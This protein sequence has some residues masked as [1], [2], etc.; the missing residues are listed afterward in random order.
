MSGDARGSHWRLQHRHVLLL[1]CTRMKL[2]RKVRQDYDRQPYPFGTAKALTHKSWSL[3]LDW[4]D[5][6]CGTTFGKGAEVRVLFAGCGD[7]SEAFAFQRRMPRA[8]IV[9]VDFS[10]RSI[11]V[12]RRLQRLEAAMRQIH[13][14]AADLTDPR[15]PATVGGDFD[16]IICHGVLSYITRP[17]RALINL[18]RCLKA[19]GAL[20]LGVNG[21]THVS[22]RL[23]LAL[24]LLGHDLER[25]KEGE[26][27]REALRLCDCVTAVEG[28]PQVSN[29]P[30]IFVAGDIFGA[31]NHCL[32][33]AQWRQLAT[34]AGL[35]FRGNWASMELFRN[36]AA[37]GCS[38]LVAPRSRAEVAALLQGL[39][40]TQFHRL[41]F[42]RARESN[43][44]WDSKRDLKQWR[45]EVTRLHRVRLPKPRGRIL[46]RLRRITIRSPELGLSTQWQM[47]DWELELIRTAR[48][49]ETLA[50][51]L[52]RL[53]LSVPFADLRGQLYLLYQLGVIN[54]LPPP[55]RR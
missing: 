48:G 18:A 14:V 49:G 55:G 19:E 2:S 1:A 46:D 31:P 24:P 42:S 47:P 45:V 12:A 23:R 51:F 20:Y 38:S 13:F 29:L 33:L 34:G 40:P 11:A 10:A 53:P 41:I 4:I 8:R 17:E 43:P 27:V 50:D 21:S 36:V 6:V 22:T 37:S 26:S 15:L 32:S 25:F 28:L 30:S 54:L 35:H 9:A 44:P 7:G 3:S 52:G 39:C 5:A 16:L